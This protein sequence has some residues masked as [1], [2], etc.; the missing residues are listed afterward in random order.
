MKIIHRTGWTRQV[1]NNA[2]I[3]GYTKDGDI[4]LRV[5]PGTREGFMLQAPLTSSIT[6]D[7]PVQPSSTTLGGG[8]TSR[9]Q[10]I[11]RGRSVS[12]V[13]FGGKEIASV[14][15]ANDQE[16]DIA[17]M[18]EDEKEKPSQVEQV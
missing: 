6:W 8:N 14:G 1:T 16:V 2:K 3:I 17:D 7:E 13:S 18:G 4:I 9:K 12:R 15:G 5:A 11:A 10:S